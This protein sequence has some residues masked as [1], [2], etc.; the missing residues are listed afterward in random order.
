[1]DLY[2]QHRLKQFRV[3]G[4]TRVKAQAS[5]RKDECE[6]CRAL[7]GIVFSIDEFPEYPPSECTCALGCGCVVV[8][9][10]ETASAQERSSQAPSEKMIEI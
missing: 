9:V 1:M 10:P 5:G 4:V 3:L 7:S 8:G 2:I 6:H